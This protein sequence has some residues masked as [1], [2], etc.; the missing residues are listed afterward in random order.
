MI[1]TIKLDLDK[2]REN[3]LDVI[4]MLSEMDYDI[5]SV[6]W[7]ENNPARTPPVGQKP[8]DIG[9]KLS[10]AVDRVTGGR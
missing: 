7:E 9:T 5:I 1:I 3:Y 2:T 10:Q 6:A 8:D 4:N